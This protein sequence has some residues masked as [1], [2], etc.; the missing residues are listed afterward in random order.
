MNPTP[1]SA[2]SRGGV[3]AARI[4]APRGAAR[5]RV[6]GTH[7]VSQM[8]GSY[9][10]LFVLTEGALKPNPNPAVSWAPPPP[11]Y[12]TWTCVPCVR[13]GRSSRLLAHSNRQDT[14]QKTCGEQQP[15]AAGA[16]RVRIDV[17]RSRPWVGWHTS[18]A[19]RR[20]GRLRTSGAAAVA[21]ETTKVSASA[22]RRRRGLR[23][24]RERRTWAGGGRAGGV[25]SVSGGGGGSWTG[26]QR[27]GAQARAQARARRRKLRAAR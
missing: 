24:W 6:R 21:H 8:V 25:A 3:K 4:H 18:R 12:C 14:P 5:R 9:T 2:R 20:S 26:A 11:T 1:N 22:P 16:Q 19:G 7:T 15:R 13:V 17:V 10:R 23:G 27:R